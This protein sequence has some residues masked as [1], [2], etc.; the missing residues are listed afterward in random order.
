MLR[1]IRAEKII[2]T[3]AFPVEAGSCSTGGNMSDHSL[4]EEQRMMRQSCRDFVDAV[5]IPF[6]RGNW[7]REWDT[8]S[9]RIRTDI[10]YLVTREPWIR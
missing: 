10:F 6:I 7:Q 1:R 3:R 8:D 5:V 4:S 9:S 2:S